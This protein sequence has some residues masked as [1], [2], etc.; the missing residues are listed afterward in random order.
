LHSG[1]DAPAEVRRIEDIKTM[2]VGY[3]ALAR[4]MD[5]IQPLLKEWAG[6]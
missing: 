2:H 1:V 6:Q 3:A 5:E 4:K